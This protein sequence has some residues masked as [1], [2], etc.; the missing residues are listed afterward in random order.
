[1]GH[2][3]FQGVERRSAHQPWRE[4]SS[5]GEFATR[6]TIAVSI[7]CLGVVALW[8]AYQAIDV[9]LVIF[10]GAVIAVLFRTLA[11]PLTRHTK[12]PVW[13]AV[14][15]V[16]TV[17][18]GLFALAG[19]MTAPAVSHQFDELS[20]RLPEA[21]DRFRS[22]FL[23]FK[24][25]NW[26]VEQ[27]SSAAHTADGQKILRQVTHA[28]SITLNA[29]AAVIIVMFLAI[30]MATS[31]ATYVNGLARLVPVHY[32]PRAHEVMRELYRVLRIW[33]MTKLLSMLFV[34]VCVTVGLWLMHVPLPL[35]L[36]ILAGLFEFIPTVGP[37]L[38]A[39]P[40]VLLGFV[41]SPMTGLYVALLYFGVQWIQNHVTNPLL[42][43]RTLSLPPALTLSLVALLGTFFG[44][45]GLFLSGPLSVVVI[46][47][48]KKLYIEDVL[49]RRHRHRHA[50]REYSDR[51]TF[52]RSPP[53][54]P[55]QATS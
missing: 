45:G 1:M 19:W 38:S 4:R 41:H 6:A 29:V 34:A 26:L 51:E 36:G 17:A 43:Q 35:A 47:L 40:A 25:M 39:A 48:V 20:V 9:L 42:Q 28:F 22:Q 55:S 8:L 54:A 46:V 7:V 44:V 50:A 14:L 18:L 33:L 49:E 27:G 5:S 16:L 24:W 32:R 3:R 2:R 52:E 37:L 31:P 21:I 30:Y 23:S 11:E 15:S 10:A 12:M 13:A 53:A